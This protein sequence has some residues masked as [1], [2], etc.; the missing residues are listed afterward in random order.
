MGFGVTTAPGEQCPTLEL[1]ATWD[2]YL[3]SQSPTRRQTIRRKERKLARTHSL[4]LRDFGV[5]ES[6][7]DGWDVLNALHSDRWAGATAFSPRVAEFHRRFAKAL[8]ARNAL[9]LTAL[10]LDGVAAAAWYGFTDGDTVFFFQSGRS[11]ARQQ[12]SVGQ[13]LMG[14]MIRRAIEQGFRR[15]DFLRGDEPYKASW[16]AARR[17]TWELV[18]TR[19][20]LHGA[21]VRGHH[22]LE[23]RLRAA[24]AQAGRALRKFARGRRPVTPPPMVSDA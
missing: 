6:V 2:A 13:V 7:D 1:P 24:R 19:P 23:S 21:W 9:W 3:A 15:F 22:S 4:T 5:A 20:G 17:T 14:M 8:A 18:V 16:T 10:E 12:E 11:L